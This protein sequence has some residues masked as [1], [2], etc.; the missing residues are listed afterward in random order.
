L[1]DDDWNDIKNKK[2]KKEKEIISNRIK[3]LYP[4]A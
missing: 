3:K 4:K 1:T 2:I